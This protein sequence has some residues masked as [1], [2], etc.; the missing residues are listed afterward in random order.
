MSKENSKR[1]NVLQCNKPSSDSKVVVDEFSQAPSKAQI[2]HVE[3]ALDAY[4]ARP[5]MSDVL[6]K[7]KGR[8]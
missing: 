6:K 3:Q 8:Q 1:D 7:L 4:Y 5:G 2:E